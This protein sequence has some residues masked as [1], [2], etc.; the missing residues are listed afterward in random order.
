ME[1][2]SLALADVF[3]TTESP[4]KPWIYTLDGSKLRFAESED[5]DLL[6]V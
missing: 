2:M 4:R 1:P 3:S 6:A 5:A